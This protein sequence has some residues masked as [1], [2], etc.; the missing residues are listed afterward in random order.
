MNLT[1]GQNWGFYL[2]RVRESVSQTFHDLSL[3]SPIKNMLVGHLK[4]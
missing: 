3:E 2:E 4:K 1:D